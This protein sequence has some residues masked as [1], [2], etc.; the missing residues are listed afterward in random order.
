MKTI[1]N[2]TSAGWMAVIFLAGGLAGMVF[3]AEK[4]A[5]KAPAAETPK[6]DI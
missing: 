5:A 4:P 3:G 2:N 6:T 1:M